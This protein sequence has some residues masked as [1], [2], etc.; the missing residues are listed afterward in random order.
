MIMVQGLHASD[1]STG[2]SGCEG[3]NVGGAAASEAASVN[4]EEEIAAKGQGFCQPDDELH[5]KTELLELRSQ[6]REVACVLLHE[7]DALPTPPDESWVDSWMVSA[8]RIVC[9]RERVVDSSDPD[10]IA[11]RRRDILWSLI[12]HL[13][14]HSEETLASSFD[15]TSF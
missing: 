1:G 9:G 11:A 2:A 13:D 15:A 3:G 5:Y 14:Q 8:K 7:L 4:P 10:A 12:N 6:L